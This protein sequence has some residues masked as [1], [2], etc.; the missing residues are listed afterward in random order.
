MDRR[1][2]DP[3]FGGFR[4][5]ALGPGLTDVEG[6]AVLVAPHQLRVLGDVLLYQERARE[7]DPVGRVRLCVGGGPVDALRAV[8]DRLDGYRAGRL[9]PTARQ[10]VVVFDGCPDNCP[11]KP[12]AE[13]M[14]KGAATTKT[15]WRSAPLA[16]TGA[17]TAGASGRCGVPAS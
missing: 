15:S 7:F 8:R 2:F 10:S 17:G 5:F 16:T 4:Y 13:Q 12:A 6:V 9:A 11:R 1:G 14:P 3:E